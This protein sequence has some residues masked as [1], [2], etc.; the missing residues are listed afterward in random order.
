LQLCKRNE[1]KAIIKVEFWGAKGGRAIRKEKGPWKEGKRRQ[2]GGKKQ[3]QEYNPHY[4]KNREKKPKTLGRLGR[5]FH[6]KKR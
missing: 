5:C 4:T 6:K 3:K 2:G 1:K